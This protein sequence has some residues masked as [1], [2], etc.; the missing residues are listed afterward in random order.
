MLNEGLMC[1]VIRITS[2]NSSKLN[3]TGCQRVIASFKSRDLK[4][5]VTQCHR[6]I[7]R[8]AII[9]IESACRGDAV[10]DKGHGDMAQCPQ[11]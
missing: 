6:A 1:H 2:K 5:S 9:S 11:T 10:E 8:V 4:M 7:C 3:L